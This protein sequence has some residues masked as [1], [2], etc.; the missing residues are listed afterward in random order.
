[1]LKDSK[2]LE[3]Q[4]GKESYLPEDLKYFGWD[5]FLERVSIQLI[6]TCTCIIA[7][8]CFE[9]HHHSQYDYKKKQS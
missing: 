5:F 7:L 9:Q 1:M 8:V 4:N 2:L 6:K 3:Q